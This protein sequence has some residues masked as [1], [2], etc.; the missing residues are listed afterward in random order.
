MPTS[1]NKEAKFTREQTIT[2]TVADVVRDITLLGR[3]T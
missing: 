2:M 1:Q 3:F